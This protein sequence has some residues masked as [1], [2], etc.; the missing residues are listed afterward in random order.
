[1]MTSS[2][3]SAA[4]SAA[5][6][7]VL[8]A[9]NWNVDGSLAEA[10][11]ATATL[12][13]GL[14]HSPSFAGYGSRSGSETESGSGGIRIFDALISLFPPHVQLKLATASTKFRVDPNG[15]ISASECAAVRNGPRPDPDL[16]PDLSGGTNREGPAAGT[17]FIVFVAA[18]VDALRMSQSVASRRIVGVS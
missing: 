15:H 8:K 18:I 16:D 12:K 4:R 1:M 2:F 14:G 6:N 9:T 10:I 11:R 17:P 5:A 13:T 3:D 7:E